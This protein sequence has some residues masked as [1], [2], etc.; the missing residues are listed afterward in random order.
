MDKYKITVY[1]TVIQSKEFEVE[2]PSA[3]CAK[4]K[5]L[6]LASDFDFNQVSSSSEYDAELTD[7]PDSCPECGGEF[8][9]EMVEGVGKHL[10]EHIVCLE[11]GYLQ[12]TTGN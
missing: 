1:R 5:A 2:A 9:T 8:K 3:E 7:G 4:A 10:F 11:C 6:T 12:S